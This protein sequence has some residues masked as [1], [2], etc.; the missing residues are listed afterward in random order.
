MLDFY[1]FFKEFFMAIGAVRFQGSWNEDLVHLAQN[2]KTL[3]GRINDL[4]TQTLLYIPHRI[5]EPIVRWSVLPS[6]SPFFKLFYKP[7]IAFFDHKKEENGFIHLRLRTPDHHELEAH[8]LKHELHD[9]S[10]ESRV[11][12]L[13]QGNAEVYQTG[14]WKALQRAMIEQKCPIS[15]MFFNP[16]NVGKSQ[17]G[18]P[19]SD[20]L[21][22]DAETVYQCVKHMFH[23]PEERI[24][25]YGFSLGGAQAA[26][27]KKLH[28]ETGGKL[29]LDR[30]FGDLDLQTHFFL[31]KTPTLFKRIACW[32]LKYFHWKFKT[33]EI[34][35][36]KIKDPVFI[37]YHPDDQMIPFETS[38][39]AH[40]FNE[41]PE[42]ISLCVL[43]D[44][45]KKQHLSNITVYSTSAHVATFDELFIRNGTNPLSPKDFF[46]EH[47]FLK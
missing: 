39:A 4:A 41:N 32:A 1:P 42:H 31:Q 27:L 28:P 30:T 29:I 22:L 19:N 35:K 24:D 33:C 26:N 47:V 9:H 21:L 16:R 2:S 20:T 23:T 36:E 14:S 6:S 3:L 8:F 5:V 40:F 34:V 37:L 25:I 7:D 13:F 18:T 11:L 43:E 15:L 17:P 45:E 38:L 12:I 46:F 44:R 10:N